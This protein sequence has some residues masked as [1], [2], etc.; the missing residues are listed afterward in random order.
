M[1]GVSYTAQDGDHVGFRLK[2]DRIEV[3]KRKFGMVY[4]NPLKEAVL[5]NLEI[6]IHQRDGE[7]A[8]RNILSAETVGRLLTEKH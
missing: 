3:A 1:D 2:V 7:Q 8:L 5:S 6:K 4:L